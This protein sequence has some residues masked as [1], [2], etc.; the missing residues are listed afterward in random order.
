MRVLRVQAQ[1][2]EEAASP[3]R[4]PC[5]LLRRQPTLR[6]AARAVCAA[7]HPHLLQA[8]VGLRRLG[9]LHGVV[10]KVHLWGRHVGWW[11]HEGQ[12]AG[13]LNASIA[14]TNT[15]RTVACPCS[16]ACAAPH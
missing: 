12:A 6:G 11:G 5:P 14:L 15:A 8:R 16:P 9:D 13:G 4:R 7:P 2:V 3:W 1:Q 10:L